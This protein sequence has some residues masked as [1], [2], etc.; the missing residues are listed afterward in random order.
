M[1]DEQQA[2]V[3]VEV[4]AKRKAKAKP[5]KAKGKK[6]KSKGEG[7]PRTGVGE[8]AKKLIVQH[9]NWTNAEV[10]AAAQK[11]HPD[12]STNAAC[13]AWYRSQGSKPKAKK[14]KA[15]K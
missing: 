12:S 8:T 9:P 14:A 11:K 3:E 4:K 1:S 6:A 5:K 10:A 15:K 2:E 13:V 7:R